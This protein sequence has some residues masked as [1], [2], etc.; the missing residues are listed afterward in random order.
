MA[1]PEGS[2]RFYELEVLKN[3]LW[4]K[5]GVATNIFDFRDRTFPIWES[6]IESQIRIPPLVHNRA[7]NGAP[8][9][10]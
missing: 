7:R 3:S 10:L 9:H 2:A 5:R 4:A 6:E 8:R 1:E